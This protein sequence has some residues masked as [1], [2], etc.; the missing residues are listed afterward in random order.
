MNKLQQITLALSTA[1]ALT[2][3]TTTYDAS[4]RPVQTVDAGA[5]A[6]GIV[7]AGVLGAAIANN[8]SRGSY[9]KGYRSS[10]YKSHYK[11][12]GHSSSYGHGGYSSYNRYGSYGGCG[13]Y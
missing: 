1:F 2:S 13:G 11:H 8:N 7:A 6:I 5:A 12:Q 9:H 10:G 4:G 3:C